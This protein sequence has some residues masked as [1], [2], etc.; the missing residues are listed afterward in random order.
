MNKT[1]DSVYLEGSLD[2]TLT[3]SLSAPRINFLSMDIS[4]GMAEVIDCSPWAGSMLSQ[5][6]GGAPSGYPRTLL[7]FTKIRNAKQVVEKNRSLFVM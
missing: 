2:V 5:S 6:R 7:I 1:P 4:N 3:V